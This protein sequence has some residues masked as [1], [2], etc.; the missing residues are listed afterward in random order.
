MHRSF[1]VP[2]LLG[3]W[4]LFATLLLHVGIPAAS[5]Q[6]QL[7]PTPAAPLQLQPAQP[8]P[9]PTNTQPASVIQLAVGAS[10][11][12]QMTTKADF[13][14][15]ENPNSRVLR[16]ERSGDRNN[17]ILLVG[18]N[19]GRTSVT[20]TDHRDRV[21]VHEVVVQGQP[22]KIPAPDN[23]TERVRLIRGIPVTKTFGPKD[24]IAGIEGADATKVRVGI[25]P[26]TVN[27]ITVE[28]L[29]QGRTTFMVAFKVPERK[30]LVEVDI[31]LGRAD[32]LRKLIAASL[33]TAAITV[34]T[35]DSENDT[36]IVSGMV[37]TADDARTVQQ[38]I[39]L[40]GGGILNNVRI[41][42]VQQVQLEVLVALVNRSE[43]RNMTFSWNANGSNWFVSSLLGASTFGLSNAIATAPN[44]AS[45]ALTQTGPGNLS[46]G[47]LN[48]NGSF[49]G[50]LQALRSEGMLKIMAEP[51]VTTLSGR[52]AY[53]V[54]GGETP[55]LT[56]GGTGAPSVS[57]KQFGT[58]VHCLPIVL[59][60]GK[61]HLEVRPEISEPDPSLNVTIAGIV[62][63][64]VPGFRTRSAQAA[65]QIEDGQTVAIGGLIQNNVAATI[66][67]VPILGDLPFIGMA[68]T[69]KSYTEQEQELIILVTPRLIDPVDCT[70]IPK[71]LPG[72]ESRSPDDFELFM[73]GIMEAPRGPRNVIDRHWYRPAFQGAPNYGQ[74]PCGEIHGGVRHG[75]G[76]G[77]YS[78]QTNTG[79]PTNGVLAR[80][81]FSTNPTVTTIA[82][83]NFPET[84]V[85]QT[86]GNRF[87]VE[88]EMPAGA[89]MPPMR[90][91]S[92]LGGP[93]TSA[94]M[95]MPQGRE[96]DNRPALPPAGSYVPR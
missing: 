27:S 36:I 31:E 32:A 63:T 96:L 12:F 66:N 88:T 39:A 42:G 93:I 49:M 84:G 23:N 47:I 51:R 7:Q 65:V 19:A 82:S 83:P 8:A 59:G 29:Q 38:L 2:R 30:L 74:I 60:N 10:R 54:S 16:V 20:F 70:K 57:Y 40:M 89:T 9:G 87:V 78:A 1:S 35:S 44:A 77:V 21:E 6:F 41:G 24:V 92:G 17:E 64:V 14:R 72:R 22:E 58:V 53:I 67:R 43:G 55:I 68:F 18:E 81:S 37:L 61:I 34:T 25:T 5:A 90:P 94:P 73:E 69:S 45:S 4:S 11:P 62:P 50:F 75:G 28:G 52:P 76:N 13:K 71:Y 85:T 79:M 56:S 80:P 95:P 3:W 48:G 91:M 46:F 15:V 33:P 86:S 26:G